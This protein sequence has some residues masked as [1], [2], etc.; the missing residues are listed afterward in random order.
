M[1]HWKIIALAIFVGAVLT[2]SA[3]LTKKKDD[4]SGVGLV[5]LLVIAYLCY[6]GIRWSVE[7]N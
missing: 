3:S 6:L 2:G 4:G 1:E 5:I 7:G